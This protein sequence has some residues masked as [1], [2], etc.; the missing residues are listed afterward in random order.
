MGTP[1]IALPVLDALATEHKV[2]AV[3]TRPDAVSH[4][5]S[6]KL[7]SLVK[8][9]ATKLGIDCYTPSTFYASIDSKTPLFDK[10]GKRVVDAEILSTIKRAAP[11]IIVV[12]AYGMLLPTEIL[13]IP[14]FGCI[15][16]HASLLPRWR[17][18]API[19]RAL[20]AGDEEIGISIMRM[21]IGLDT[22]PYCL[23]ASTP[24]EDKSYQDLIIELGN[25]SAELLLAN[26]DA[27]VAGDVEWIEQDDSAASYA[28]KIKKGSIDLDPKLSTAE[29]HN[30]VRASSHHAR[31]RSTF[32][33]RSAIILETRIVIEKTDKG[34]YF[35]CSDGFLEI[36]QLKP[37]GSREMTGVAFKAGIQHEARLQIALQEEKARNT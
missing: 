17:G 23:Q 37:A 16:I 2:T 8:A 21:D 31:C 5:G 25:M 18:A 15:N 11:D 30:R 29:N 27:I 22:G 3:F 35:E 7:P 14:K 33:C 34:L 36:L 19:Q 28:D 4:R 9:Q 20:L 24:A 32:Y 6:E 12:I 10:E 13:D 26:L 1:T